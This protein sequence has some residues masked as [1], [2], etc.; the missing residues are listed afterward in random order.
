MGPP[1]WAPFL[2]LF[3]THAWDPALQGASPGASWGQPLG[4]HPWSPRSCRMLRCC[5]DVPGLL[6]VAPLPYE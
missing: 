5:V 3:G 2:W 6:G 4:L 1:L